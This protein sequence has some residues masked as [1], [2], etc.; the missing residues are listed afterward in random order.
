[1]A[2]LLLSQ[3]TVT[4]NLASEHLELVSRIE[5]QPGESRRDRILLLDVERVV[6]SGRPCVSTPVLQ[7]FMHRGIPVFFI[8]SHGRWIG[9][10]S[11]DNNLNAG[12]RLRQYELARDEA[13]ALAI[14]RKLVRAKI[15]N[16][17][18][19]LQ[20]LSANRGQSHFQTQA[21]ASD[22][23]ENMLRQADACTT[24][25]E[26][27]GCEGMAAAAY[28]ARLGAFFP[29]N[30]PFRERSRRP[31]RNAANAL[32]SWTYAIVQG[33]IDGAVRSHGLDPC[34]GFLHAVE[35]GR[36][37]LTL[38]LLEPLRAPVCDL[39]VLHLLNHKVLTDESFE[40]NAEDGGTYLRQEAKAP[41]FQSY[42]Q[43]MTRRFTAEKGGDHTDFRRVIEDSVLA[44]L[45]AMEGRPDHDFF[46]M[47]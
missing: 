28:F 30:V 16:Q 33:E 40:F 5:G 9:T 4:V 10:L 36:P 15:R 24:L 45:R 20:R 38:D 23:L 32:L 2:T 39:L 17:R 7:A 26:L 41:F 22:M 44:V 12:R 29:E 25:D 35:H 18:R 8:T 21:E 14:S 1:M 19:V 43:A 47:P 27:R 34:L 42:E 3:D 31:P 13:F 6:V 46:Q 11:P 37:S